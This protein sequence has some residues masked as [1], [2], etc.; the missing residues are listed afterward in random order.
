[1]FGWDSLFFDDL[2]NLGGPKPAWN[3]A[4]HYYTYEGKISGKILG[5]TPGEATSRWMKELEKKVREKYPNFLFAGN[6]LGPGKGFMATTGTFTPPLYCTLDMVMAEL[7]GG[8][9]QL[10]ERK[11]VGLW[12]NLK[13]TFDGD[14]Q[15]RYLS[16][17]PSIMPG[18]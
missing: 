3:S 18:R 10:G 4:Y 14:A 2:M 9:A 8:G 12:K 7:G 17:G 1:M 13:A 15:S 16:T 6:L 11:G 5:N